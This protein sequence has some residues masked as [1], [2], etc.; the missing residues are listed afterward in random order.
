MDAIIG[1]I[2]AD[3][4]GHGPEL[5]KE[6][7]KKKSSFGIARKMIEENK[8][9]RMYFLADVTSP[10][11]ENPVLLKEQAIKWTKSKSVRL[12]GIR[13][14]SRRCNRGGMIKCQL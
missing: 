13:V 14:R 4:N 9:L 8:K 2:D 12:L 11:W 3:S 10:L 7:E 6:F 5:R 1:F